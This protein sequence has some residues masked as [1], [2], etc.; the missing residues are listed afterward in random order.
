AGRP[1]PFQHRTD[2]VPDLGPYRSPT[3]A[4]GAR[5][6][7]WAQHR[8]VF[9]VVQDGEFGAPPD[10]DGK[11]AV[12]TDADRGPQRRRPLVDRPEQGL[13][14]VELADAASHLAVA[15]K[16]LVDVALHW[17]SP[18]LQKSELLHRRA[19][20]AS[21]QTA[22]DV[23]RATDQS[24]PVVRAASAAGSGRAGPADARHADAD[25]SVADEPSTSPARLPCPSTRRG[26]RMT[27]TV[28]IRYEI[29]P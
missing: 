24:P 7:G 14:P 23:P 12:E 20:L 28:F 5:V 9:V 29:D 25:G 17:C 18:A 2:D 8:A 21:A 22:S 27:I 1:D 4:E 16:D 26:Y 6:L 15:G 11:R 13:R 3:L 10:H 19:R